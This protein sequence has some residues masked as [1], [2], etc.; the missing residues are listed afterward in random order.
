[1]QKKLVEWHMEDPEGRP[2]TDV[3]RIGDKTKGKVEGLS[4]SIKSP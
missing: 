4:K 2:L 3:R 1:M